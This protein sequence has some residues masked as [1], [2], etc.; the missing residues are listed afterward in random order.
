MKGEVK[1]KRASQITYY[2]VITV[3]NEAHVLEHSI[4]KLRRF[5]FDHL[6]YRW[7]VLIVDNGSIDGTIEVAGKLAACFPDVLALHLEQRGRGR[8]LRHAWTQ[9][10]SDVVCYMDVDLSTE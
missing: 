6:P 3:L 8:A 9:S 5:L 10:S 7:R 1:N 4:A 2:V